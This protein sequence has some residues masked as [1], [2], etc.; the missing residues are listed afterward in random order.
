MGNDVEQFTIFRLEPPTT[1]RAMRVLWDLTVVQDA[2][3]QYLL[4]V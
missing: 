1:F 2:L 4:V 3:D